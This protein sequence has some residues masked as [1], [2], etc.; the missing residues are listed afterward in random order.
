MNNSR[1]S[2]NEISNTDSSYDNKVFE[3]NFKKVNIY[4]TIGDSIYFIQNKK[5]YIIND[6]KNIKNFFNHMIGV[7]IFT[8]I[9]LGFTNIKYLV[10]F[11]I[12][13]LLLMYSAI[14]KYCKNI[15]SRKNYNK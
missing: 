14:K 11:S 12:C 4:K 7:G 9:C 10:I 1:N 13:F 8:G 3:Y 6:K 2:K 5:K 15:T